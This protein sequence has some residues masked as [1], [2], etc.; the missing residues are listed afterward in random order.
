MPKLARAIRLVSFLLVA[1]GIVLI[2]IAIAT[3][4][5]VNH[6]GYVPGVAISFLAMATGSLGFRA[7]DTIHHRR[8][9]RLALLVALM[10]W[11]GVSTYLVIWGLTP[12]SLRD[13]PMGVLV[14][15]VLMLGFLG[16]WY[17]ILVLLILA[18]ASWGIDWL[19][20]RIPFLRRPDASSK[21]RRQIRG[22][23]NAR[24]HRFFVD[25]SHRP[26]TRSRFRHSIAHQVTRVLRLRDGDE[27][28]LLDG[29]GG[30]VRCRLEGGD[31]VVLKRR[32]TAGS[33]PI[34]SPS[35]RRC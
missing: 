10:L 33:Q 9:G 1:A 18:P 28:T 30:Q 5:P 26:T 13:V 29:Q 2:G 25:L 35:G 21:I 23:G 22:P 12:G 31:C 7:A 27:I 4:E 14:G 24:M 34:S 8:Y 19:A 17:T 20:D 6:S 32:A 16:T 3:D 11:L 15:G